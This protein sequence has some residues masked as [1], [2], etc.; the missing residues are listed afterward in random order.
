MHTFRRK[1]KFSYYQPKVVLHKNSEKS[2]ELPFCIHLGAT[3]AN[4]KSV[5]YV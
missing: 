1:Q 2:I 4:W 3:I 5:L